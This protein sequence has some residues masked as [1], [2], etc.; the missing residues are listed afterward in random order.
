MVGRN[1]VGWVVEEM[2]VF[3]SGEKKLGTVECECLE[4]R[5]C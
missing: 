4:F 1:E 5:S 3:G 2:M